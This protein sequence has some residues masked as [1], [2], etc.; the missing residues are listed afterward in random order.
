M[1]SPA[2]LDL[3]D[4]AAVLA[5]SAFDRA[6]DAVATA[7]AELRDQGISDVVTSVVVKHMLANFSGL[8]REFERL[9]RAA[10]VAAEIGP[11]RAHSTTTP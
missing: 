7:S 2:A 4:L 3:D 9:I 11:S 10:D 8:E 5:M 6:A 1:P